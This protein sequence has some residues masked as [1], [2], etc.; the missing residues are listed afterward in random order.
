MHDSFGEQPFPC[1]F[2]PVTAAR[3]DYE[4]IHR[5]IDRFTRYKRILAA[6]FLFLFFFFS[7]RNEFHSSKRRERER[8]FFLR[9]NEILVNEFDISLFSRGFLFR[10]GAQ[11]F[12]QILIF[13]S[14]CI[15]KIGIRCLPVLLP[16]NRP[17]PLAS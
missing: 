11:S 15:K 1:H 8:D 2:A 17:P 13:D 7:K 5:R 14:Y 10:S 3:P 4:T 12:Q 6:L 16:F 9:E